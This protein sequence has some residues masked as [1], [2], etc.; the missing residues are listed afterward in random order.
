MQTTEN[1]KPAPSPVARL[2]LSIPESAESIGCSVPH[3]YRLIAAGKLRSTKV[4]RRT[5]IPVTALRALAEGEA[6]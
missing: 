3:I 5:V 6:A 4:G 1:T 2:A